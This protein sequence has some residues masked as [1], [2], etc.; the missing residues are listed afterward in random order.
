[1]HRI[2]GV[3]VIRVRFNKYVEVFVCNCVTNWGRGIDTWRCESFGGGTWQ[4][5][6][7]PCVTSKMS[8]ERTF[9]P[10]LD[11]IGRQ[12]IVVITSLK[13]VNNNMK[14]KFT[15]KAHIGE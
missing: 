14:N 11:D 5:N 2:K 10:N 3:M 13:H 7:R 12:I 8:I 9:N 4:K 6:W 15:K 1:M